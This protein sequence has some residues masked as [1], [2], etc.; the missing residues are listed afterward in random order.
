MSNRLLALLVLSSTIC[1]GCASRASLPAVPGAISPHTLSL[2]QLSPEISQPNT[3]P[4]F[5]EP[6]SVG[7]PCGGGGPA[8]LSAGPDH[9]VWYLDGCTNSAYKIEMNGAVVATQFNGTPEWITNGPDGKMWVTIKSSGEIAKVTPRGVVTYFNQSCTNSQTSLNEIATGADGNL[10]FTTFGNTLPGTGIGKITPAGGVTC[11]ATSRP[12]TAG[13][14]A[15]PDGNVWFAEPQAPTLLGKISPAGVLTEYP[16]PEFC[17]AMISAGD[18]NLY[19][20][21]LHGIVRIDTQTAAET[22]VTPLA[23]TNSIAT[24]GT[25]PNTVLYYTDGHQKLETLNISNGNVTRDE[26]PSFEGHAL[27][28]AYGP[29]KNLW[30]T[31]FENQGGNVSFVGVHLFRILTAAPASLTLAAGQSQSVTASETHFTSQDFA[32]TSSNSAVATIVPSGPPGVFTVKG[33]AVG[34]AMLT[35]DDTTYN[36]VLISVT[37]H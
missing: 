27:Y 7:D 13:I 20:D 29:D 28:V 12:F 35:I 1:A 31:A 22:V 19:C 2:S 21:S 23:G 33:V 16:D 6:L 15:G 14:V 17:L 26:I 9:T 11:F 24:S 37:V 34:S 32:G 36:S 10:W 8:G 5:I 18:G 25:G 4:R 30:Y 3:G